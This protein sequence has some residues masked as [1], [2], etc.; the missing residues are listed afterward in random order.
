M[1]ELKTTNRLLDWT[2]P[3][4]L[5]RRYDDFPFNYL[6]IQRDTQVRIQQDTTRYKIPTWC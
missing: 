3:K 4:V 1:Q 2:L 5:R 6:K